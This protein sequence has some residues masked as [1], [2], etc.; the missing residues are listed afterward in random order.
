MA[1]SNLTTP[2]VYVQEISTLPASVAA[3]PTAVPAFIGYTEKGPLNTATRL[4]S[5]M[6]FQS[7]FGGAFKEKFNVQLADGVAP[8]VTPGSTAANKLS[9]YTLFYHMQM[10]FAN[11]GG[12]CYVIA[13]DHY[14]TADTT[15]LVIDKQKLID[16][17]GNAEL[18]DEVTLL[19][20]PETVNVNGANPTAI[21][22]NIKAINDTILAQCNKLK[23]RFGV[24][25]VMERSPFISVNDDGTKF[26]NNNVGANYLNYGAAYYPYLDTVLAHS[27]SD[28]DVV[29]DDTRATPVYDTEPNNRLSTIF[30]G[31][32]AFNEVQV[33][34]APLTPNTDTLN[35]ITGT[36]SVFLTAGVDF[37][38]G[39]TVD[40]IAAGLVNAINNHPVLSLIARAQMGATPDDFFVVDRVGTTATTVTCIA[41]S[42]W[43]NDS[44][45]AGPGVNNSQDIGLYNSIKAAIAVINGLTLPPAATMVGIYA[46]VDNDRGVW[47]APANVSVAN[48]VGPEI[49]ITEAQQGD[50]NV[51]AT[52]GKSINAIRTFTGRGTLVWGARTLDGNSN[53]WRYVPVRRLFIFAEESIKK[54]TEFVVFEP[55]DKNTW[56]RVKGTITNFLTDLW[57]DGALAGA[58]P[59]QAFFVQ[60]GLGETMTAQDILEGRMIVTIGL[61]AV[62][63]AEFIIL[64]FMH[65]L[66]E[67]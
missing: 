17:I 9:P 5:L 18:A 19:V 30:G 61:A 66:Q 16:G 43:A 13:A 54:A 44:V 39:P 4:T 15:N 22:A 47:K 37:P 45:S 42:P 27:F 60:V 14:D 3:V 67:A 48:I 52:S 29:I 62:R 25:D 56:L 20:V 26:R 55:N 50:L 23:D 21:D 10:F 8:L 59:D 49:M 57:R 24:F 32:G 6:D 40:D 53:E 41:S 38:V 12:T 28:D 35:V 36:A 65:K 34:N 31:I 64:Q 7:I 2:G 1:L 63:P 46:A 11:G 51:D 58:K 33:V